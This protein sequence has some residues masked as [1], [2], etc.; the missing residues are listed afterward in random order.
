M[1]VVHTWALRIFFQGQVTKEK[2]MTNSFLSYKLLSNCQIFS[3]T[4]L[5]VNN[6]FLDVQ[7][8]AS[9]LGQCLYIGNLTKMRIDDKQI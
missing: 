7:H 3:C 2:T 5:P 9:S 8:S 4:I 6:L 1:V